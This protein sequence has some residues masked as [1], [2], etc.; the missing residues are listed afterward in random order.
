MSQSQKLVA[1]RRGLLEPLVLAS[2]EGR[3]RYPAEILSALRAADFPVQEGSLYPLL[4]R[5]GKEGA[6]AHEWRES[7]SGPPR[8]YLSLTPTGERQ[9]AEFKAYWR[10][11]T[12]TIE[13]IGRH[14]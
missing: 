7:A 14:P 11:L 8:K 13:Q 9:L 2:L 5:L 12:Q 6:V 3:Q 1:M 10:S 4:T